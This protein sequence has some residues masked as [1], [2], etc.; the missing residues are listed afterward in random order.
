MVD[1]VLMVSTITPATAGQDLLETAVRLVRMLFVI[2]SVYYLIDSFFYFFFD[3]LWLC[4]ICVF[5][6]TCM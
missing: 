4:F 3:L 1:R 5:P 6:S 2:N